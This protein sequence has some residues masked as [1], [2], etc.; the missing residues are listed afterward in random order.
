[1]IELL[2]FMEIARSSFARRESRG[3]SGFSLVETAVALA[4]LGSV[5]LMGMALLLQHPRVVKRVDAERQAYRALE[6]T[7]ESVRAGLLPLQ[8][9]TLD[10]FVTAAGGEPPKGLAISMDVHPQSTPG[11]Y[12][13]TLAAR[14]SIFNEEK[15][16]TVETMVWR[17]PR[18]PTP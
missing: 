12:R 16:K 11:L 5:L 14:Y 2:F 6:S 10:G 18:A 17:Q 13:V 3:Q 15:E 1:L 7:L 4:I 9:L 8:P